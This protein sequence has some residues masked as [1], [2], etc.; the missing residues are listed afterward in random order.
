MVGDGFAVVEMGS[1]GEKQASEADSVASAVEFPVDCAVARADGRIAGVA[2]NLSGSRSDSEL[3]DENC[4]VGQTVKTLRDF[5][6]FP[7]SGLEVVKFSSPIFPL[8]A[9]ALDTWEEAS[10]ESYRSLVQGGL[11][12]EGYED[13]FIKLAHRIMKRIATQRRDRLK[14]LGSQR[15]EEVRKSASE[16]LMIAGS[17]LPKKARTRLAMM[18]FSGPTARQDAE[19]AEKSRWLGPPRHSSCRHADASDKG[20]SRSPQRATAWN[21]A[22]SQEHFATECMVCA[23]TSPG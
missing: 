2:Q 22:S 1:E 21:W 19:R 7:D 3:M 12:P 6:F 15:A 9:L 18:S 16:Q 4:L 8:E 5:P 13:S 23:R 11:L 14:Q 10:K 17:R 20:S